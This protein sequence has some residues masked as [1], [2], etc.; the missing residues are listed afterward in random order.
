MM[1]VLIAIDSSDFSKLLTDFVINH[2][3]PPGTQFRIMH[4]LEPVRDVKEIDYER[5]LTAEAFLREAS[6]K[7]HESLSKC[8]VHIDLVLGSPQEE[9]LNLAADWPADMI[10]IGSHGRGILSRFVMGSVSTAVVLH[11]PCSVMVV[12]D[13][14]RKKRETS[15][16]AKAGAKASLGSGAH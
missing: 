14:S 1:K 15:K 3:W 16:D 10:V 11:S 12:R 9:I 2:L 13:P 5:R 6:H 7:I 8:D 4:C